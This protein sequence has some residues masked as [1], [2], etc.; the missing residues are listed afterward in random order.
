M[1]SHFEP[2]KEEIKQEEKKHKYNAQKTEAH[3]IKF[4]S[5]KEADRYCEL[6]LLQQAKEIRELELQP[7]FPLEING[8]KIGRYTA[9]FRY[10]NKQGRVVVEEVKGYKDSLYKFR[11]K[12]F[13]ALYGNSDFEFQVL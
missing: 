7:K 10:I 9:D 8:V 13:H 11:I 5:K 6:L 1:T 4:A 3:G 2:V 12:V